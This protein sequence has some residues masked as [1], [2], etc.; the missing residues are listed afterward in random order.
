MIDADQL[1]RAIVRPALEALDLHSEPAEELLLGTIAQESAGGRYVAQVQGP[2][3]GICQM[4]PATHDDI[5]DHYLAYHD[6]LAERLLD[7]VGA[8]QL[9]S[10][11]RLAWDLRYA[12]AMARIHYLRV[13]EPLPEDLEDQADYWK[14]HY[15]T[16]AGAGS[17]EAYIDSYLRRIREEQ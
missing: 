7:A 16:D 4:E 15:N 8:A 2:A 12:V 10:A 11:E 5:W 1:R 17:A 9:P 3:L 13:D 14:R 6:E